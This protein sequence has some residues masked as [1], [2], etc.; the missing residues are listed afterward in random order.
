LRC[1]APADS[2]NTG[3]GNRAGSGIVTFGDQGGSVAIA[4]VPARNWNL[5]VHH[6]GSLENAVVYFRVSRKGERAG[7]GIIELGGAKVRSRSGIQESVHD[8]ALREQLDTT[9][10]CGRS[11]CYFW[12]MKI[13]ISFD[14]PG[15]SG[16]AVWLYLRA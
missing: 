16:S 6:H 12:A 3:S 4:D 8:R 2:H 7:R 11:P 15:Q 13:T 9:N 1:A 14:S 5:A 10:S